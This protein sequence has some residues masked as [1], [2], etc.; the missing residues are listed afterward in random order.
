M[1]N[2]GDPTDSHLSGCVRDDL[3]SRRYALHKMGGAGALDRRSR[4]MPHLCHFLLRSWC[5]LINAIVTT[6]L[7]KTFDHGSAPVAALSR[8][9]ISVP[10]GGVYGVLGQNGAGKSTLFR[11]CLGLIRPDSG[12]VRVLD[13]TPASD[14]SQ[15]REVGSMIETPRLFDYLTAEET[16]R[17]L[18]ALCGRRFAMSPGAL[19]DLVGLAEAANRKVRG[20]S[21]GM[22]Q[23]LGIAA[24]LVSRPKLVI[25][26]E[27]TSGLDPVGNQEIRQLIRE[28]STRDGV[29]VVLASHQL[30][31]VSKLCDR[32][33]ILHKGSLLAEGKVTELLSA[34]PRLRL[35]VEPIEHAL[36]LLGN[37]AERDG[38]ALLTTLNREDAPQLIASLV[39]SGT[40]VFEARWV[41]ES[42]ENVFLKHVSGEADAPSHHRS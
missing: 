23:R 24:A 3:R 39:S 36:A 11:I 42:L 5:C 26:D 33:A 27:P 13:R 25:L 40:K 6:E 2:V 15:C 4:G 19:L 28:L 20:F 30:E 17:M 10:Q 31:E 14:A 34:R 29:T 8:F 38:E 7:G 41:S 32:V 22:K 1:G 18:A 9:S 12:S 16:L 37:R 35:L 21:V